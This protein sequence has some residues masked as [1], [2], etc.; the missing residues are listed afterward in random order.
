[1]IYEGKNGKQNL[2]KNIKTCSP[3]DTVKRKTK[4][5]RKHMQNMSDEHILSIYKKLLQLSNERKSEQ[6]L[7][8]R[9][10]TDGKQTQKMLYITYL[11]ASTNQ[12]NNERLPQTHSKAAIPYTI[13]MWALDTLVFE[14]GSCLSH[15]QKYQVEEGMM[16]K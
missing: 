8:Q 5:R 4:T 9:K 10:C 7:R 6:T 16:G 3:G 11:Q 2:V 15:K 13:L 1:M 12:S 14:A